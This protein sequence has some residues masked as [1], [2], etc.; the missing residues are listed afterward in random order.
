MFLQTGYGEFSFFIWLYLCTTQHYT[1]YVHGQRVIC[2][3]SEA[4][5]VL[6]FARPTHPLSPRASKTFLRSNPSRIPKESL[7][8]QDVVTHLPYYV[9]NR[10]ISQGFF[11]YM[12]DEERIIGLR[13]SFIMKNE[14]DEL[15]LT[16]IF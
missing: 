3:T 9:V 8:V 12:I 15:V 11:A 2:S 4:I 13:V 1:R 6:D 7:F 16:F 5:Q 10:A 14:S